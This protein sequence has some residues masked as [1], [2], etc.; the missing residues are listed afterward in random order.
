MKRT[1]FTIIFVSLFSS[2]FGQKLGI[3]AGYSL[4]NTFA[5]IDGKEVNTNLILPE[6]DTLF[7]A[8]LTYKVGLM[9]KHEK[10][11]VSITSVLCA[12]DCTL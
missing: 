8:K 5:N 11:F 4:T 9:T 1:L 6:Y 7:N 2:F 10:D 3:Q 12:T